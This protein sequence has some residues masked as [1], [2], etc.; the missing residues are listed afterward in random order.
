M[1]KIAMYEMLLED[2][3]LWNKEAEAKSGKDR[4][5]KLL[6][7]AAGAALIATPIVAGGLLARRLSNETAR[8]TKRVGRMLRR[9]E[10]ALEKY[11]RATRGT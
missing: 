8:E 11:R 10:E 9:G 2:H 5:K 1:D 4:K 7:T 6:R 3:P